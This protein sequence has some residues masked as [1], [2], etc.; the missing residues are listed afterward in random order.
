M[1]KQYP[2]KFTFRMTEEDSERLRFLSEW[3]ERPMSSLLRYLIFDAW[4]EVNNPNSNES[5]EVWIP[6]HPDYR[7]IRSREG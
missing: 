4:K 7:P 5:E 2:K 1:P 3:D 6:Y